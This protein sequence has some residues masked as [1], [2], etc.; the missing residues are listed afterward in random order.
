MVCDESDVERPKLFDTG[1]GFYTVFNSIAK[2]RRYFYIAAACYVII[3]FKILNNFE[4]KTQNGN[5][6]LASKSRKENA[7]KR[8]RERKNHFKITTFI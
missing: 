7:K 2:V 5:A 4:C 8:N 3:L 6:H 1:S